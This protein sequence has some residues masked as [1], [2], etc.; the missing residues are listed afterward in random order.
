MNK[1]IT[2]AIF[3][4]AIA[5]GV[6]AY[7]LCEADANDKERPVSD[8]VDKGNNPVDFDE[9][10]GK[11]II[12]N[13]WASWCP[14]CIAEMPSIHQLKQDLKNENIVFVMVSF[15][16]DPEKARVFMEKRHF[17][18]E[19]Y[20]PGKNYPYATSSI[21]VTFIIDKE[22]NVVLKHEGMLDYSSEEFVSKL[23]VLAE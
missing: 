22:G 12:V 14:P 13:N 6:A 17:D 7:Q 2:R 20:F 10:K 18:L 15:D 11:V 9:F 21:P 8:L 3:V 19:V 23:K 1:K 16:E 4:L 5:G